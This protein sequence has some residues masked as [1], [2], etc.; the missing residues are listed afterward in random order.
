MQR[1]QR[2]W[3]FP[4]HPNGWFA[5]AWSDELP[6]GGVEPLRYLGREFVLYRGD[7]ARA[8]VLDA[9]CRHLGAHMGY[10][11]SVEGCAIRCP[12]HGWRWEPDGTCSDVPYAKR[13]PPG[14]KIGAWETCE[15][16]GAV[17]VWH[18]AEGKPPDY[19]L[20][21]IEEVGSDEWSEPVR[22][23]WK[24]K[25]RLY[26]MAENAFDNQHFAA[27]HGATGAPTI[28]QERLGDGTVVNRSRVRMTTPR[29]PVEG[30]I[31]TWVV[32]SGSVKINRTVGI[33]ETVISINQTPI[34]DERVDVRFAYLQKRTDDPHELRVGEAMLRDLQRQM[35]QDIAIFESKVQL[36]RPLLVAE[37]GPIA[38]YRRRAR[39][40]YSGGFSQ[41]E[42]S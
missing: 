3:P 37:D 10:G 7:D 12:F 18:H 32:G 22:L 6:E 9:H 5:V 1:S 34:D 31:A 33:V 39:A 19:E 4:P 29:G 42:E 41:G 36:A 15:R 35:Q 20:P 21:L 30:S 40:Y 26:D 11:G 16:N 17:Y 14:A 24:V 38:D 25:S 8:R 2:R 28:E 13:I 23:R 27:L